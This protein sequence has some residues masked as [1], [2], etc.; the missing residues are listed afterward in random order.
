[1]SIAVFC[2]V[3]SVMRKTPQLCGKGDAVAKLKIMCARSM[4]EVVTALA[5]DFT[6]TTGHE[7]ELD[8]GTVGA[9]Q[10]R[11]D[12]GETT[13]VVISSV[14]A[15]EALERAGA[16]APQSRADIATVRIGV[17]IR[18]GGTAPD[19][20][21]PAAFKQ[22]LID[23]DAIAFSDAAVG[24]SAG[25]YLARM[26]AELGLAD[27][28]RAKG[29]P[30]QNGGEVA[31]RVA[32]GEAAIGMTLIAEIVPIAGARVIGPL[33]PPLGADTTYC[34]AVMAGGSA[35]DAAR[36]FIAALRRPDRRNVWTEAG[37]EAA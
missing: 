26:F 20:S 27:M 29:L 17:A 23:A 1:L 10:Q 3:D 9:L 6:S 21:T 37:F 36:A 25:V 15:I 34:A 8:F 12:A 30:Q 13:D 4:H 14:P 31:K 11:L 18:E 22:A 2:A 33:P 24:G 7:T 16:L 32:G 28:I 19:I 5:Y 35:G